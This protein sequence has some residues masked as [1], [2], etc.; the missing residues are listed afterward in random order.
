MAD[1]DF[2]LDDLSMARSDDSDGIKS[3]RA[4][5]KA[6][7]A[8]ITERDTELTTFREKSRAESLNDLLKSKGVPDIAFGLYPKDAAATEEAVGQWVQQFGAAFGI[9][10][11]ATTTSPAEQQQQI[12]RMQQASA[13]APPPSPIDMAT[14][15]ARI[16]N[17]GSREELD[18]VYEEYGIRPS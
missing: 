12:Q 18:K 2:D 5:V 6:L 3:L 13:E 7:K 17:A 16:L 9:Q 14:L 1:L 11:S 10:A 4:A 8:Q 15:R